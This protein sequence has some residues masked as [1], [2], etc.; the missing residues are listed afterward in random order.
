[1]IQKKSLGKTVVLLLVGGTF[2]L[3]SMQ[4]AFA[5]P[6]KGQGMPCPKTMKQ[7]C[8][9]SEDMAKARETFLKDSKELR[10]NMMVKR[11][12]MR[13]MMHGTNPDPE[14]VSSLAGEIFDIKE[15]LRAKAVANGLPPQAFMGHQGMRPGCNKMQ[16]GGPMM[17]EGPHHQH[18]QL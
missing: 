4:T 12:M 14:K 7:N 1:M 15:Q 17:G 13:A 2:A 11:A 5:S 10:K 16:D 8:Q 18:G 6:G 3:A 9:M